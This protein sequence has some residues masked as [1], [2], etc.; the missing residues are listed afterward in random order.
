MTNVNISREYTICLLDI[1]WWM[2]LE[3]KLKQIGENNFWVIH[4]R[5][6]LDVMGPFTGLS[7]FS[8]LNF[9]DPIVPKSLQISL[10]FKVKKPY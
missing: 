1:L 6:S 5:I 8:I 9:F 4:W 10:K 3:Q 7:E 2:I